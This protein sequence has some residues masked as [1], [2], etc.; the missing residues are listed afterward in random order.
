MRHVAASIPLMAC[1]AV[2]RAESRLG[3]VRRLCELMCDRVAGK[4]FGNMLIVQI[5]QLYIARI[6]QLS[7]SQI[8]IKDSNRT[9][10]LITLQ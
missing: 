5:L 1:A 8:Q 10:H 6:H 3:S 4:H 2:D 7:I 9:N